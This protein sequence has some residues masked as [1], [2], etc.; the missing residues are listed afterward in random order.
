MD[1]SVFVQSV[2]AS[3][4]ESRSRI[5]ELVTKRDGLK[6]DIREGKYSQA[7]VNEHV[8]PQIAELNRD[9]ERA[10]AEAEQKACSIV[11]AHIHS[12]EAE[13]VLD[14]SQ[15]TDDVALLNCGISLT[16][17]DIS[18]LLE[19]NKDNPTMIQV[20][21]RYANE[22]GLGINLYTGNAGRIQYAKNVNGVAT[23]YVKN[24]ITDVEQG[25][26]LLERYFTEAV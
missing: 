20:L 7:Y 21:G 5:A 1:D 23:Q 2:R 24:W 10:T 11:D 8:N 9:I 4:E 26:R 22:H 15:L 14:G 25:E 12:L 19:K 6:D 3:L 13:D 16:E 18:A 17:R